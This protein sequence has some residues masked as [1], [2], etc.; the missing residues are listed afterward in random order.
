MQHGCIICPGAQQ[1]GSTGNK[2]ESLGC[3]HTDAAMLLSWMGS[4]CWGLH[5]PTANVCAAIVLAAEMNGMQGVGSEVAAAALHLS[6]KTVDRKLVQ[7]SGA[8][9]YLWESMEVVSS[10]LRQPWRQETSTPSTW[11]WFALFGF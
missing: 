6:R 10:H 7:V 8:L 2:A 1:V 4:Q 5:H 9:P 3:L 11:F